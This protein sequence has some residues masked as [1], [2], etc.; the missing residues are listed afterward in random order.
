MP[1]IAALTEKKIKHETRAKAA[2]DKLKKMIREAENRAITEIGKATASVLRNGEV[3]TAEAILE[4]TAK[5]VRNADVMAMIENL[6]SID[7]DARKATETQDDAVTESTPGADQ[8]PSRTADIDLAEKDIEVIG[9]QKREGHASQVGF[10][11]PIREERRA[12]FA[13]NGD[14]SALDVEKGA[15]QPPV[16]ERPLIRRDERPPFRAVN[17]SFSLG[18]KELQASS[19]R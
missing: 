17:P 6:I 10:P 18:T 11:S 12:E 2:A 16:A 3:P 13:P 9:D 4:E 8:V 15:T 1:S 7:D 14:V 19:V 5:R